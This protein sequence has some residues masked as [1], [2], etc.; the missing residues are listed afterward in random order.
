MSA[1]D[2]SY[3]K[4]EETKFMTDKDVMTKAN[5]LRWQLD[6]DT[7]DPSIE[8][9]KSNKRILLWGVLVNPTE[10]A[11]VYFASTGEVS[12]WLGTAVV[13]WNWVTTIVTLI[14][15]IFIALGITAIAYM[16]NVKNTV[17]ENLVSDK[18]L[19][20]YT[21]MIMYTAEAWFARL[22]NIIVIISIWFSGREMQATIIAIMWILCMWLL[23]HAKDILSKKIM[24]V[25]IV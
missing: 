4:T 16:P 21:T 25:T 24:D 7:Y 14:V 15:C 3:R 23:A 5:R 18:F 6:M 22:T 9:K 12:G 8:E 13:G 11:L 1:I 17:K 2:S 19:N 20:V 10:A